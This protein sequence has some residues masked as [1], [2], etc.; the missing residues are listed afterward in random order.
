MAKTQTPVGRTVYVPTDSFTAD[1]DGVPLTFERDVT[2]VSQSWLDAHP[3]L[4]G[5]FEPIRVHYE[6][7]AATAAPGE[8]RG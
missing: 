2:R 4:V 8:T 1:V 6:W 3:D 7:E 5:L